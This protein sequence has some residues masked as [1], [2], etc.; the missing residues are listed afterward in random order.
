M[1]HFLIVLLLFFVLFKNSL[2]SEL[3]LLDWII[4]LNCSYCSE[5]CALLLSDNILMIQQVY[6]FLNVDIHWRMWMETNVESYAKLL[7]VFSISCGI[8]FNARSHLKHDQNPLQTVE[9]QFLLFI[10]L[11][12]RFLASPKT[13]AIHKTA[14]FLCFSSSKSQR[15]D[16]LQQRLHAILI[17]WSIN[18]LMT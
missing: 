16:S 3:L 9:Q 5:S 11:T 18:L 12:E 14:T 4:K 13:R 15:R 6:L 1:S 10:S 17:F 7:R 2:D 8:K